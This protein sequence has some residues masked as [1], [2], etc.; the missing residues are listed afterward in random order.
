MALYKCILE[1]RDP[2][3]RIFTTVPMQ[4]KVIKLGAWE[5]PELEKNEACA[6]GFLYPGERQQIL[7]EFVH[8][9]IIGL[10]VRRH[11]LRQ[12]FF[13]EETTGVELLVGEKKLIFFL[14]DLIEFKYGT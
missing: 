8:S 14:D 7:K 6:L 1:V 4:R 11:R 2:L 12:Q 13:G 10:E 5:S 3:L 9:G